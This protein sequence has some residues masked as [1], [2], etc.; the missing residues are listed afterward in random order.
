MKSFNKFFSANDHPPITDTDTKGDGDATH[1]RQRPT[2]QPLPTG[3]S[4]GSYQVPYIGIIRERK[5]S[6]YVDCHS[7]CEKCSR[8]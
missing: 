1:S 6:R 5:L 4:I 2:L 3:H 8:F 7:V